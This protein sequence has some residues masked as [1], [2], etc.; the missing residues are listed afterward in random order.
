MDTSTGTGPRPELEPEP[1]KE[2]PS[3]MSEDDSQSIMNAID[4]LSRLNT[5]LKDAKYYF[6][7][8][9]LPGIRQKYLSEGMK[10]EDMVSTIN[11]QYAGESIKG[12]GGQQNRLILGRFVVDTLHPTS[13]KAG[14]T[15]IYAEPHLG[16]DGRIVVEKGRVVNYA[17]KTQD[18]KEWSYRGDPVL[19]HRTP[20]YVLETRMV[21]SH[22][23]LKVKWIRML[24]SSVV[25]GSVVKH[26]NEIWR[27]LTYS[28]SRPEY[29]ILNRF[30]NRDIYFWDCGWVHVTCS[31][32]NIILDPDNQSISEDK[33]FLVN[34][35][36]RTVDD[37][38]VDTPFTDT[39]TEIMM[40]IKGKV[41]AAEREQAAA[42]AA[43]EAEAAAAAAA[44]REQAAAAAAAEAAA[45]AAAAA[46]AEREQ[47][48]AAA[49]AAEAERIEEITERQQQQPQQ[50]RSTVRGGGYKKRKTKKRKSKKTK[51]K[52]TKRKKTKRKK[53]KRRRR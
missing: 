30:Q 52:K 32:P 28:E 34:A 43:A 53:T 25:K 26:T 5:Q 47:A 18:G 3:W 41:A 37:E 27:H 15:V 22:M 6:T 44:E 13:G 12:A 24:N 14:A 35:Q 50:M 8:D 16:E 23:W 39:E 29:A 51:R 45:A 21:G 11:T 1:E 49:A 2:R 38:Y 31:P 4:G 42:A 7:K 40:F 10:L 48:A 33:A 17:V 20:I 36:D 9:T 46:A 19:P